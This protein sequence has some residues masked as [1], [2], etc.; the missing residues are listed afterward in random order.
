ML[1]II[2]VIGCCKIIGEKVRKR[3]RTAIGYQLM[4]VLLWFGGEFSGAFLAAAS[5]ARETIAVYVGGLMGAATGAGIG[6]LI[7]SMLSDISIP[8]N[9]SSQRFGYAPNLPPSD[10]FINP[11]NPYASPHTS[12][13][14]APPLSRNDPN[15]FMDWLDEQQRRGS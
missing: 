11:A 7:V 6:F 9:Y 8:I 3:G 15:S 1:E 12:G 4:F 13:P 14:A 2:A 10:E 5:G